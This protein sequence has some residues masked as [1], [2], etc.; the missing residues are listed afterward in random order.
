VVRLDG[1][2]I[3]RWDRDALGSHIGYLPQDVELFAGTVGENIARFGDISRS[4]EQIIR[5]AR[6]AHAHEMILQLPDGY[7]TQ[8]G[9][10][11]AVLSGGQR[12][13]IALARALFGNPRIVVLDEPDA[14]LDT[15]GAAA[16]LA[17]IDDMKARS[18]T[19]L[20]VSHNPTLMA[21][22]DRILLLKNGALDMFGP[23]AAVLARMRRGSSEQRVVQ[24]P[25]P[26]DVHA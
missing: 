14:N 13:R 6:L 8:I 19:V 16:L 7:D 24:F 4:S 18:I 2:D 21:A 1:A 5:A 20:V 26:T 15:A 9:E 12:Q 23:A 17:A 11:G 25:Q 3:A 22:V 10:A